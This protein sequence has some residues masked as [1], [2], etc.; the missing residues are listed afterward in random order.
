MWSYNATVYDELMHYGILGM[1]WGIRRY[2][3][4]PKG[5]HG[6]FLGQD[7]D[8]DIVIKKGSNAYRLQSSS[9]FTGKGQTYVSLD[10]LD[11]YD[12][13]S[14]TADGDSGLSVDAVDGYGNSVKLKISNDLIAP[15]YQKSIDAFIESVSKIGV[16]EVSKSINHTGY[17]AKNFIKDMKHLKRE[18]ARDRAYIHF[19]GTMMHDSAQKTEFFNNL[20]KQ[21]YNAVIDE[22][23][24]RFDKEGHFTKTPM[25][26]FEKQNNLKQVDSRTID[27]RDADYIG[28]IAFEKQFGVKSSRDPNAPLTKKLKDKWDN[29]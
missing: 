7:R 5:K 6:T 24:K 13:I 29:Y 23:D 3:P 1:K 2:Q 28:E 10:K 19:I 18:E 4:Y 27:R 16:K 17:S 21:G 8:E 15:S 20:K 11:H 22:W 25:I 12:Y 9:K 14:A 26:V